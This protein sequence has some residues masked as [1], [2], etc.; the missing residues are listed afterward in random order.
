MYIGDWYVKG[1]RDVAIIIAMGIAELSL[2]FGFLWW[3][4]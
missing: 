2:I 1:W 4:L 3:I